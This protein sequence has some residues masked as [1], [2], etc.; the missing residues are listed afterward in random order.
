MGGIGPSSPLGCGLSVLAGEV[1]DSVEAIGRRHAIE[2]AGEDAGL[3]EPWA[4]A[5]LALRNAALGFGVAD[6]VGETDRVALPPAW[7]L[8]LGAA[9]A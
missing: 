7:L 3:R 9:P 5:S 6:L 8:V 2:E 1:F 4:G